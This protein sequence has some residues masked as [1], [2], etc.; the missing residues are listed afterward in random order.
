MAEL[1][2]P[3]QEH[4]FDSKTITI[5]SAQPSDAEAIRRLY[6]DTY[7][8]SYTI[9][10]IADP[11]KM[12]AA[13]LSRTDYLWI[14]SEC[15]SKVV[16]SVIFTVDPYHRLG[17]AFGGVIDSA[18]RG[19]KLIYAMMKRGHDILLNDGSPCDLIYAVVRTFVSVKFHRNLKELGYL[20]LGIF[21]NV[22]KL[23]EYET[24]TF[25]ICPGP[26][27]FANRRPLP[28][29]YEQIQT[30]YRLVNT[31]LQLGSVLMKPIELEENTLPLIPLAKDAE[32]TLP[33][34]IEAERER[35][36]RENKLR[37]G[38]CP[39]LEPNLMLIS[40][41]KT[42][43]AFI[44][45]H[46]TDGHASLLGLET[47]GHDMVCLLESLAH[48]C[49][50]LQLKYLEVLASAY[51]PMIQAQL[52][53]AHFIPSAWF[54]AARLDNGQRLDYIIASRSFVP[55]HFQGL[56]LTEDSKPYLLEF[57][58]LYTARIWEEL[59]NA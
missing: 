41:D 54:P 28:R 8:N 18:F 15:G 2:L 20:D 11:Q 48:A 29:I 42:V 6:F 52:W 21:P 13:L 14:I 40:P 25:K 38:F 34:D 26:N 45:C 32:H 10:E 33:K 37:F 55:L 46:P 49:E 36:R 24:H 12:A 50:N 39:L 1:Y 43:K 9:P 23:K 57:F 35:L 22:R 51:D 31:K 30:L 4:T 53:Q 17:K 47:G 59:V 56:Q 19:H 44:N 3:P 27:A 58:K 5:R 16:G 7:G